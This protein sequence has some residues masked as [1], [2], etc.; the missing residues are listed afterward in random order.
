MLQPPL[1]RLLAWVER[2]WL[3]R[4]RAGNAG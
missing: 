2:K 4:E 3:E 1:I